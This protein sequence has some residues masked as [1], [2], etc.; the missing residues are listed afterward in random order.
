EHAEGWP[1][2][3]YLAYLSLRD[4]TD[5][6]RAVA[7]FDGSTRHVSDYLTEVA[8][9]ALEPAVLEFLVETSILDRM[10]GPLCAPPPGRRGSADLLI[11]LEHANLF[12]TALDDHREWYRYHHLFAE[13]LRAE[14]E[15]RGPGGHGRLPLNRL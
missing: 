9:A 15:R 5:R 10:S 14:L 2:G 13:L 3:L 7:G 11:R 8:L 1:A 4:E 12:L 6:E